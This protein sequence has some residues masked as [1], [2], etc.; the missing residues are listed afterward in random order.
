VSVGV[1][2]DERSGAGSEL[3]D[4]A[5]LPT[6]ALPVRTVLPY[7]H[8]RLVETILRS[9]A[10]GVRLATLNIAP[11]T[12]DRDM[13]AKLE[14]ALRGGVGISIRYGQDS[15]LPGARTPTTARGKK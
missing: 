9:A 2:G 5:Q 3:R 6:G 12:V 11:L 14:E 8:P 7:E 1:L 13:I 15:K 4:A 10:E